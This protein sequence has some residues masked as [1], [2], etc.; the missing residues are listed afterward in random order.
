MNSRKQDFQ[1]AFRNL[2]QQPL[3]SVSDRQKFGVS[4]GEALLPE[5]QQL[6]EDCTEKNNQIIFAGHR[7]C[8]KSTLLAKFAEQIRKDYFTVFFSIADLIETSEINHINILF[9]IALQLMEEAS[10]QQ[11]N[12]TEDKKE[13]VLKWFAKHTRT[14]TEGVEAEVNL[15]FDLFS[16]FKG[17]LKTDA[18]VREQ[19]TQEFKK[20]FRDLIDAVNLIA[21]EIEL[22]SHKNIVVII[23]DIDKLDLSRIED[24]FKGN[25]KALLEPQFRVIYTIPIATVRDAVLKKHIEDETGNS[26]Y[27]MPVQKLFKFR[28]RSNYQAQPLPSTMAILKEILQKRVNDHLFVTGIVEQIAL[29]SGGVLA[30]LIRLAQECCRLVRVKMIQQPEDQIFIEN[31]QIDEGI[32][33]EALDN[34]RN[35]MAITLSQDDRQI[36]AKVYSDYYP[37]DPKQQEFLDLLHTIYVI[38]YRNKDSWYDVNPLIVEQLRREGK[39]G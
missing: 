29:H 33:T 28:E 16:I 36:L 11:L 9:T 4:Y 2:A 6:I 15:G 34:L 3:I 5:L 12:I 22:A 23:D 38:E 27:V 18:T 19:I 37:E 35:G 20:N 31:A 26:I 21:T 10:Q 32:L 39:I 1:Q 14:E 25:I 13:T 17:K 7:G 30:E 8:G 24:I